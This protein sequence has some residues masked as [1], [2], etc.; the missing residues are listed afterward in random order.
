MPLYF[1][2]PLVDP[3][4]DGIRPAG[5][6]DCCFYCSRRVGT[7]HGDDCVIVHKLV[8]HR[9]TVERPGRVFVG[10]WTFEEPYFWDEEF[11]VFHK[12]DSSWCA[13]NLRDPKI[14]RDIVWEGATNEADSQ[15]IW[16]EI[17][18][19]PKRCLC[20]EMSSEFVR[21]ADP[22]PR[23]KLTEAAPE[24]PDAYVVHRPPVKKAVDT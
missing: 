15:K 14:R 9:I 8:E 22:R 11:S 12:N 19:W 17:E 6:P 2:W 10:S 24:M 20:D 16:D 13:G 18:S 23:R 5:K 7:V 4:D 21:V 1:D 3:M